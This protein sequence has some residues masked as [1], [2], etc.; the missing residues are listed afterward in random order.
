MRYSS[1]SHLLTF[2]VSDRAALALVKRAMRVLRQQFMN[3]NFVSIGLDLRI[4]R[5]KHS[6]ALDRAGRSRLWDLP[7]RQ[8]APLR[9]SNGC[10]VVGTVMVPDRCS[11]GRVWDGQGGPPCVSLGDIKWTS[12]AETSSMDMASELWRQIMASRALG[13]VPIAPVRDA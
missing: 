2:I 12:A 3:S 13:C 10:S 9:F 6:T 8:P 7:E 5:L 4:G 11:E 1:L